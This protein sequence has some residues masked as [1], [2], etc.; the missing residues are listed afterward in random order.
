MRKI[1]LLA[2]VFMLLPISA[3]ADDATPQ[4]FRDFMFGSSLAAAPGVM[5]YKHNLGKSKCY[6]LKK[7]NLKIGDAPLI[8]IMYCYYEDQLGF[9]NIE[10]KIGNRIS[11]EEAIKQKYGDPQIRTE[12][13]YW[14]LGGNSDLMIF[15]ANPSETS[16]INHVSYTYKPVSDNEREDRKARA[17][18]AGKDL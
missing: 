6:T 10:F 18:N 17:K 2:F 9:I 8:G 15:L 11:I 14:G 4:K 12:G 16:P 1:N 13:K 5:V 7:D 3:I